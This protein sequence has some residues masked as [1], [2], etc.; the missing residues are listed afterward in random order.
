[1]L[2]I[3]G[4][5]LVIESVEVIVGGGGLLVPVSAGESISE[6]SLRAIHELVYNTHLLVSVGTVEGQLGT[7]VLVHIVDLGSGER[8]SFLEIEHGV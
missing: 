7:G 4:F 6:S 1:M 8:I 5:E 2:D 3:K